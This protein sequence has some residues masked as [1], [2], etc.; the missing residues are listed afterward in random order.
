MGNL[1]DFFS[2]RH[3]P[4]KGA[5]LPQIFAPPSHRIF[6]MRFVGGAVFAQ[7]TLKTWGKIITFFRQSR[8]RKKSIECEKGM[9][10]TLRRPQV[11]QAGRAGPRIEVVD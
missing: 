4:A 6:L 5:L 3:L 10:L 1:I 8:F 2:K 11:M 9:T 7:Q